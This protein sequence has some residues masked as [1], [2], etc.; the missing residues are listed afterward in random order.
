MLVLL[1]DLSKP[2]NQGGKT[3]LWNLATAPQTPA[4]RCYSRNIYKE[5]GMVGSPSSFRVHV[6][7]NEKHTCFLVSPPDALDLWA[8]PRKQSIKN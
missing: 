8:K 1:G 5:S 7:F 4:P 6:T 3:E 2:T